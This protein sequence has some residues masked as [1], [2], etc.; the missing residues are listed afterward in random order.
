MCFLLFSSCPLSP[1]IMLSLLPLPLS[2]VCLPYSLYKS[3][4]FSNHFSCISKS[5]CCKVLCFRLNT[6]HTIMR[7][8]HVTNSYNQDEISNRFYSFILL[9]LTFHS[10]TTII[11]NDNSS[12]FFDPFYIIRMLS[13][14]LKK[15]ITLSIFL[16]K[17]H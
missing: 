13:T 8:M 15:V 2:T 7:T 4:C 14:N 11:I 3:I 16:K 6:D 10:Y 9:Y 17:D 1:F 5:F 12:I